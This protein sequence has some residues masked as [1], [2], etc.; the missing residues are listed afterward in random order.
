MTVRALLCSKIERGL[1]RYAL[2]EV[3]F[4]VEKKT[5][6]FLAPDGRGMP[7]FGG[8]SEFWMRARAF[9]RAGHSLS[10]QDRGD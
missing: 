5:I 6:F 10:L 4:F 8:K 7:F 1:F 3:V 2:N 9:L